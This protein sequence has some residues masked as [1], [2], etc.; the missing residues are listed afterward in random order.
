MDCNAQFSEIFRTNVFSDL[1]SNQKEKIITVYNQKSFCVDFQKD[2][3]TNNEVF[4]HYISLQHV[5]QSG[6]S[7]NE[8]PVYIMNQNLPVQMQCACERICDISSS[9]VNFGKFIFV[10]FDVELLTLM[11]FSECVSFRGNTFSL[12]GMVRHRNMHFSCAVLEDISWKYINDL[13]DECVLLESFQSLIQ[14]FS[15][16]W[17]FGVCTDVAS[18]Q[19][20]QEQIKSSFDNGNRSDR[21]AQHL[22]V[23]EKQGNIN[24]LATTVRS[25][26]VYN[27]YNIDFVIDDHSSYSS[28]IKRKLN[29]NELRRL[30]KNDEVAAKFRKMKICGISENLSDNSNTKNNGEVAEKFRK[31]KKCSIS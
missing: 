4:V 12:I 8:W 20:L 23:V 14:Y 15:G 18:R 27:Y 25:E 17:F 29:K 30:Q 31:M 22:N 3:C 13:K 26:K 10:E 16:G 24:S 2:L 6:C 11:P 5:L 19:S 28:D 21:V 7:I 9:E 1:S